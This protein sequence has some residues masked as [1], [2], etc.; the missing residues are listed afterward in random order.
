M[1]EGASTDDVKAEKRVILSRQALGKDFA[2]CVWAL[3]PG[4]PCFPDGKLTRP[5]GAVDLAGAHDQYA[6]W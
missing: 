2:Q 5:D 6:R 1:I 3:W 4:Q